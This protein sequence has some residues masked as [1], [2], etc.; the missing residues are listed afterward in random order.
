M[1][2]F[3]KVIRIT[4]EDSPNVVLGL[5]EVRRGDQP[6]HRIQT[7]G[8]LTYREYVQRRATWDPVRQCVGLDA[9]FYEGAETLMFPPLWLNQAE[10][11]AA[12][13]IGKPRTARAIGCDPGEGGDDTCWAVGDERGL[14]ELITISTPDT[15]VITGRTIDLIHRYNIPPERVLFDRGGGGK[16]HVDRLRSQGYDVRTVAFGESLT[17]DPRHGTRRLDERKDIREEQYAYK[18]RRAEM[19]GTL[20]RLLDPTT[21][22]YLN[23]SHPTITDRDGSPVHQGI[24]EL[25]PNLR[26]LQGFATK[27][28]H[29]FGLP[30]EY[31][32]LRRQLAP[33]P[34]RYDGEGRMY[35]LPKHKR[36][37]NSTEKTLTDLIGCSPDEAD[38]V[39]L[40][41]HA[42]CG[43]SRRVMAGAF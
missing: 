34:L 17:P 9:R 11:V 13:E 35:L 2:L 28:W 21:I 27:D 29:G 41:V 25:F 32:E 18:N 31:T 40:M 33:I 7:P 10:Q 8:V 39:V 24:G 4:A 19:Y 23:Q 5:A 1:A 43:K 38:A 3:R 6:S 16:E 22:Q 30:A 14:I 12:E 20:R 37:P 42:M 15:S 36:D 26:G